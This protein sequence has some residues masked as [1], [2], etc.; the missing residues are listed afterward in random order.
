MEYKLN[1]K[2]KEYSD[3]ELQKYANIYE[4]HS[5]KELEKIV[6]KYGE[7]LVQKTYNAL[8]DKISRNTINVN[9]KELIN[10][11]GYNYIGMSGDPIVSQ[12]SM[13]AIK[14]Y[15][16]SVSASRAVSGEK[17]IHRKLEEKIAEFVG[18]EASVTFTAGHGANVSTIGHLFNKDDL[19]IHDSLIHNSSWLGT[20]LSGAK[21][22]R[23]LHNDAKDLESI[24]QKHRTRYKRALILTEGLFSMD[25]DIPDIPKY[26][27]LKKRYHTFLMVDEAHSMGVLGKTGRGISEHF[28][29]NP[30]EIDILMGTLSK[31]F[32]SCGGFV[33][34]SKKFIN[35]MKLSCPSFIYSAGMPPSNAAAALASIELLEK[36]PT[37]IK[38]L[39]DRSRL[40]LQLLK[41]ADLN[42][43]ECR[44]SPIIP[45]IVGNAVLAMT[46]S[47]QLE[48]HGIYALPLAYP[49]V[50]KGESRIRF[51]VN[52]THTEEQIHFT[53]TTLK[54][55][56][57]NNKENLV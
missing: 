3:S 43:G 50:K 25:G 32:G 11:T 56:I 48:E 30:N 49:I 42:T 16:T 21:H 33:T 35:F 13:D 45:V 15:G 4:V 2:D 41:E 5:F 1:K 36:E 17:P 20:L 12:A 28:G 52:C 9:G 57:K 47:S 29:I 23:F 51:F 7:S 38:T 34:G 53:V 54:E 14:K 18:K 44:D 40:L 24:L 37:R 55:L 8:T 10:F 39:H 27:E 31:S 46:L 19:I 6:K 22:I 26:L